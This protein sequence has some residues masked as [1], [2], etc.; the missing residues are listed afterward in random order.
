MPEPKSYYEFF[1]TKAQKE[2]EKAKGK[3]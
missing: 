1:S 2:G 3:R